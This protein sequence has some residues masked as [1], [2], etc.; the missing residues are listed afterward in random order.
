[1]DQ[2]ESD[3]RVKRTRAAIIQAFT[4]LVLTRRYDSIRTA[5]L[6]AAAGVGRSTFYEHFR[7]KEAVL[8]AA[9]DPVLRTLANAALGR[10]S[11]VQVR[12]MLEH[13]WEQRG[14]ARPLFEGR[15]GAGLERR[16]AALV[17]ERREADS[18]PAR[19]AAMAA[20]AAQLTM[21]RL[22][23][24]GAVPCPPADLAPRMLACAHLLAE[25]C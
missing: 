6:I 3:P 5:D 17:L 9:L 8:L 11:K 21:V 7:S 1:M 25:V 19:M 16:L 15:A 12:A 22:W 18:G 2:D 20:A 23:I 4:A 10:A 24:A 14:F 13:V